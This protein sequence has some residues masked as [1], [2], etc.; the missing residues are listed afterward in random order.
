MKNFG[1]D[2]FDAAA[3]GIPAVISKKPPRNKA[4]NIFPER[5]FIH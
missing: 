1:I 3:G 5:M 2:L 4:I